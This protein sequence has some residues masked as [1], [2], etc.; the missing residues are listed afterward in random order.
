MSNKYN[1]DRETYR[2]IKKMDRVQLEKILTDVYVSGKEDAELGYIDLSELKS[3]IGQIKGIGENR[4]N[5]I[6]DVIQNFVD[7]AEKKED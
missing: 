1:L 6:M 3:A 7:N 5:E 2:A 4:L